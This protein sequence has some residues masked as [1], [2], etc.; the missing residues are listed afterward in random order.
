MVSEGV[1]TETQLKAQAR[2]KANKMGHK[3]E[4]II[5]IPERGAVIFVTKVTDMATT[6]G[7]AKGNL[8]AY[9][10]LARILVYFAERNWKRGKPAKGYGIDFWTDYTIVGKNRNAASYSKAIAAAK[11]K[12][13]VVARRVALAGYRFKE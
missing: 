9:P 4:L 1:L 3:P 12:A 5:A 10:I 8:K 7:L 6:I 13:Y 2:A 11:K